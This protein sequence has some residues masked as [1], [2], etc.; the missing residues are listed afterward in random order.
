MTLTT[1]RDITFGRLAEREGA[2]I[3]IEASIVTKTVHHAMWKGAPP[4]L[5]LR[6]QM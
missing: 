2:V 6:R 3:D 1:G 4:G 5:E